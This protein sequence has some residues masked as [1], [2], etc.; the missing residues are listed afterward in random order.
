MGPIR[1]G[2][3]ATAPMNGGRVQVGTVARHGPIT[4]F[5]TTSIID[6]TTVIS[7]RSALVVQSTTTRMTPAEFRP[8]MNTFAATTTGTS[9]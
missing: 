8:T 3:M 2:P 7:S 4:T 6:S 9:E 5:T 1:G